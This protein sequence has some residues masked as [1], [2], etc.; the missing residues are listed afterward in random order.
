MHP[1]AS[2]STS[3]AAMNMDSTA[4]DARSAS[5][6]SNCSDSMK[7]AHC[8]A[9]L[10]QLV[11]RPRRSDLVD[12][13]PDDHLDRT[14]RHQPLKDALARSHDVRVDVGQFVRVVLDDVDLLARI[15]AGSEA[16]KVGQLY[17]VHDHG[18]V[19][20]HEGPSSQGSMEAG[21]TCCS[22]Y[23]VCS[24]WCVQFH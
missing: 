8:A 19:R 10:Q 2:K 24:R 22:K 17:A 12:V 9:N 15:L 11:R 14:L 4:D 20:C 6:A 16:L 13:R 21:A 23:R 5:A 18:R 3:V 7:A 1:D